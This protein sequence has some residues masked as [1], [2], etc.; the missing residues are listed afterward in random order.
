M[1]TI[2]QGGGGR[3]GAAPGSLRR[4]RG[5]EVGE[6]ELAAEGTFNPPNVPVSHEIFC[7]C[8]LKDF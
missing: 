2:G 4:A 1:R 7:P 8:D 5:S 3:F 6:A